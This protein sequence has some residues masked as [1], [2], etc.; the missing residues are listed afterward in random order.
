MYGCSPQFPQ[1]TSLRRV[2]HAALCVYV[3]R[4]TRVHRSD[5]PLHDRILCES[6]SP[7]GSHSLTSTSTQ[8]DEDMLAGQR[9]ERSTMA[10]NETWFFVPGS[11]LHPPHL[12]CYSKAL[13]LSYT[14]R[15]PRLALKRPSLLRTT[16][17][18]SSTPKTTAAVLSLSRAVAT[19]A[20]HS[21]S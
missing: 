7:S 15:P 8:R 1:V 10:F 19:T 2:G 9:Y 17:M 21:T 6:I 18:R 5:A 14:L 16:M 4:M 11:R 3:S 20:A 13:L 12:A